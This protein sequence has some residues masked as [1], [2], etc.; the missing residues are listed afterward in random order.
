MAATDRLWPAERHWHSPQGRFCR[1]FAEH[2]TLGRYLRSVHFD[3][4]DVR[5]AQRR[6]PPGQPWVFVA[7]PGGCYSPDTAIAALR[8]ILNQKIAHYGRFA[9]PT[10]LI[11]YYGKA[12]MHNTPYLGVKTREFA[13]VAAL[14]ADAVCGQTAFEKIYVLSALEPGLEAFEIFPGCA[15]CS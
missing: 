12:V 4:L 3:P 7:L 10:R 2:P 14:A 15:R 13:D 5:G 1:D 9:R 8:S 11:I 6:W